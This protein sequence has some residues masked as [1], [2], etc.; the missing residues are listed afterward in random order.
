MS[1]HN[2]AVFLRTF[3]GCYRVGKATFTQELLDSTANSGDD[4]DEM[5]V[6]C[7]THGRD[8]KRVHL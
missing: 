3:E 4:D 1:S 7:N 8:Q 5:G 2:F 6:K